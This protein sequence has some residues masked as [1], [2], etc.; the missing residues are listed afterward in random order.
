MMK[1]ERSAFVTVLAWAFI[2]LS[3]LGTAISALQNVMVYFLFPL[4]Q[5]R[6]AMETDHDARRLSAHR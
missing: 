3:G 4:A 6:A 1:S 2:V 5:L